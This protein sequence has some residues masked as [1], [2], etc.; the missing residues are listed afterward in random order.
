[1]E[2][3]QEFRMEKRRQ[4]A[5][6]IANEITAAAFT[7]RDKRQAWSDAALILVTYGDDL[8]GAID[9]LIRAENWYEGYRISSQH[10]R[11]DLAR[12]CV[13]GAVAFANTSIES[14]SDRILEFENANKRYAEVLKLR[15]QNIYEEGPEEGLEEAE[16]GSLFSAAST[17]SNISLRSSTSTS[18]TG[19]SIS[20]VISIKTAN[21]FQMTGREENNRHRSKFNKGKKKKERKIKRKPRQKPGGVEELRE[22]V[23]TLKTS[24]P[25][26]DYAETISQ[27][28]H[29]LIFVQHASLAEELFTAYVSCCD[30]I[31]TSR[32]ERLEVVAK[33]RVAAERRARS[34]GAQHDLS[35]YLVD[36]PVEKEVD[37]LRCAEL[38]TNLSDFFAVVSAK[39]G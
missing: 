38:D 5:R 6:E 15:K 1:V 35:H 13:D 25:N 28:I 36:L 33:E 2:E 29:F 39:E 27:T 11:D 24:C 32:S 23:G 14:F 22:L 34:E 7:S 30:A 12:R 3:E 19:S 31:S 4:A 37:E 10:G 20:S 8:I 17:T 16:T 9:Y 26:T 18:S 21:T